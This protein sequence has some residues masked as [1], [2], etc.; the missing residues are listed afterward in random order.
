MPLMNASQTPGRFR[1]SLPG[2][3][4]ALLLLGWAPLGA[5]DSITLK[6]DQRREGKIL[7][8]SDG[9]VRMQVPTP[10]GT[11]QVTASTPLAQ[12]AAVSMP[13]PEEFD[14]ALE[15]WTAGDA[16][17]TA[18]T[19]QPLVDN[20][21]P[22]PVSWVE[23]ATAL[24][25]DVHLEQDNTAAAA[26][27]FNRF[28]EAYPE[29]GDLTA[30]T[31]ARLAVAEGDYATAKGLLAPIV[32]QAEQTSLADSAQSATYGQAFYLMGRIRE[33]EASRP[34]ALRDY[35]RAVT[36]FY[37]DKATVAKARERANALIEENVV[38]P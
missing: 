19:L 11:G 9:T 21:F 37:E 20:F 22:L 33:Q 14:R 31:E 13:A 34:E 30:I 18:A 36:L 16:A 6:D 4:T 29:A 26:A 7:G 28:R 35:L 27:L 3:F 24:M 2:I 1:I 25:V 38:V 23:R 8:V 32:A 10:D 5:Q 17:Q 12:V 15:L